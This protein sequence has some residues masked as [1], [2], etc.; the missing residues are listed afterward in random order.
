MGQDGL[1]QL[2]RKR[3]QRRNAGAVAWD[4]AFNASCTHEQA[5]QLPCNAVHAR[6]VATITIVETRVKKRFDP[7][8]EAAPLNESHTFLNNL[9]P[10]RNSAQRGGHAT[11]HALDPLRIE[12]F[13]SPHVKKTT[14]PTP[15][16]KPV[17][18]QCLAH[19][20]KLERVVRCEER[21]AAAGLRDIDSEGMRRRQRRDVVNGSTRST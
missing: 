19:H 13:F 1:K 6:R 7:L 12:I 10:F 3:R 16:P 8:D 11:Q 18:E 20:F 5:Q 21:L 4:G 15:K 9:S 17:A 14:E 2:Q